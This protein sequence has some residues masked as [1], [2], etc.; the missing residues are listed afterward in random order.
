VRGLKMTIA[1]GILSAGLVVAA[2][3]REQRASPHESVSAS[4]DGAEISIT[5]GR[6]YTRGRDIFGALVPYGRVWCPGADEATTLTSSKPLHIGSLLLDRPQYTLWI[7]PSASE[8]QLVVSKETGQWHTQYKAANDLGR[9]TI[10]TRALDMPVDQLTF[11]IAKTPGAGGAIVF[12][13]EKTSAVI[14]FTVQK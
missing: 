10:E 7:L 11:T 5:Y 14:P 6:P 4:I 9:L 3:A 12:S 1:V 2:R 8:W 13:W